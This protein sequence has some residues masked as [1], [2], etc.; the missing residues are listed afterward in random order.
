MK[1]AQIKDLTE[2]ELTAKGREL[3]QELFN[4]RLQKTTGQLEKTSKLKLIRREIAQIE[5]RISQ[6][7]NQAVAK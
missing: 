5:T 6:I 3:R 7:R 1:F 2:A 4:L